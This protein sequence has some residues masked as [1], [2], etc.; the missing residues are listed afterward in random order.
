[1]PARR[2]PPINLL[3]RLKGTVQFSSGG[4][5]WCIEDVQADEFAR[6]S[7]AVLDAA[8]E[9]RALYPEL[10]EQTGDYH[11]GGYETPDEEGTEDYT[12]T[13]TLGRPRR[14]G[15]VVP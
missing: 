3:S 14:A 10:L 15:F 9:I 8:R 5:T 7:S 12:E 6:V 11:G 2:K 4:L 1:M 13:P